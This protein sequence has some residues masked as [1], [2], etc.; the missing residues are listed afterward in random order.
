MLPAVVCGPVEWPEQ[1]YAWRDGDGCPACAEGR[2]DV[3]P[4]GVRFF[5][6]A[7]SDAYLLRAD[8]QRGLSIVVWRGRHVAEPTELTSAEAGAYGGEVLQVGRALGT[9]LQ[10]VKLNYDLLGNSVPH[11]H[12]HIVPRYADDPRPGWP[13]P[14]PDPDPG[15]MPDDR[16]M[17]DV[18][19]LRRA[20]QLTIRPLESAEDAAAFRS[21][22]EEWIAEHFVVEEQ[23]RRQLA[24]PI[25]AYIATGGQIL[26]AESAG[27]RVG[28]VALVPDGSGAYE[29]SKMAVAADQQGRGTGRR[30]LAAAIDHAREVGATSIF[31]GSSTKLQNAVHLYEAVGFQHVA[32]ET[33]HMPYARADVFM[34]LVL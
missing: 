3:I 26:I 23:D 5:A 1:F 2:P 30:L 14:F 27:R 22:N 20:L 28:C 7:V 24:D 33:L 13:F 11:L 15:P 12:T 8:I 21:L 29:L 19:A 17:A 9:V 34:Q 31:L 16:L 25:A 32:P 6:G 10:P 18:E 4:G